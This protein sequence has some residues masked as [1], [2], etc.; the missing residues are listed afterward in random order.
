VG[1]KIVSVCASGNI[2]PDQGYVQYRIGLPGKPEMENPAKPYPPKNRFSLSEMD[3]GS[4]NSVHLKFNSAGYNYVVY[5]SA[6]SGVYVKKNGKT[7][8]NLTCGDSSYQQISPKA[9]RGIQ[10][11]DP[12][13]NID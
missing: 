7:I 9:R 12:E 11:V 1:K 4:L 8:A 5:Q 2:S 10:L 13:D 6:T 3:G